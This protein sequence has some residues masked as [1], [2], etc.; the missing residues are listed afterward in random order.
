MKVGLKTL[1]C[2]VANKYNLK[3]FIFFYLFHVQFIID[4]IIR[5]FIY[6]YL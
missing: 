5:S 6:Y 4:L 1:E 3:N 2:L